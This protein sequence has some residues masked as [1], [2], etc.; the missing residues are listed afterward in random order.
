MVN[1]YKEIK[2]RY[3]DMSHPQ[4]DNM[5]GLGLGTLNKIRTGVIPGC[6]AARWMAERY[7]ELQDLSDQLAAE[8]KKAHRDACLRRPR[9]SRTKPSLNKHCKLFAGMLP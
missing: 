1:L 3:P 7:P 4:L 8:S 5:M 6:K 9:P 2:K